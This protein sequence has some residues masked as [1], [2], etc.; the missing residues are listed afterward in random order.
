MIV[1][2][3]AKLT[4]LVPF[5]VCALLLVAL[6]PVSGQPPAYASAPSPR[7]TTARE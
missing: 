4:G 7:G 6:P 1:H 2:K 3:A 5:A